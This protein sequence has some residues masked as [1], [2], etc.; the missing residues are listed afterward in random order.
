MAGITAPIDNAVPYPKMTKASCD[1]TSFLLGREVYFHAFRDTG[2]R[3]FGKP[4]IYQ[5]RLE[6]LFMVRIHAR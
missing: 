1:L 6:V 5:R 3:A 4:P 2:K